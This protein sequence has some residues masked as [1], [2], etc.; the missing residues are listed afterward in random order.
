MTKFLSK[1]RPTNEVSKDEILTVIDNGATT[2]AI[3]E[4]NEILLKIYLD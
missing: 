2:G 4:K 1:D 3:S